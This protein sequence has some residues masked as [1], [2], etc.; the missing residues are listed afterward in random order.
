MTGG[1]ET[2]WIV[3]TLLPL[4]NLLAAAGARSRGSRSNI[5]SLLATSAVTL[6]CTLIAF[7][8]SQTTPARYAENLFYDLRI[9]MAAK[10]ATSPIVIVKIDD[11]ALSQMRDSSECRCLSPIDKAWLADLIVAIGAGRPNAIGIDY[12]LDIWRDPSEYAGFS[13]KISS[14]GSPIIA[15]APPLSRPGIDFSAP[16]AVAYADARA[17]LKDD[18]DDVV[19]S[20][21]PLP[22]GR[23]SFARAIAK[24]LGLNPSVRPMP[25]AFRSPV[26]GAGKENTGALVP[27]VSASIVKDLPSEFFEGKTVLIGRVTRSA[28]TE[29]PD[30]IED[31]HA[32]PLRFLNGHHDGTPGVEVHA[33]ALDQMMRGDTLKSPGWGFMLPFAL[34]AGLAGCIFGRSALR[35][36]AT[37]L[38]IATSLL[39]VMV[40]SVG[41]LW[42][43]GLMIGLTAPALSFIL[44][45][46]ITGRITSTQLRADRALY[47]G[48]LERYL[49]PQVIERIV[50]G[51]EPVEIGASAREI[52]VLASDIADFSVLVGATEP[53]LFSRLINDYFDGVIDI[54]WRYEAMLDKLTGDGLIAIFGAPVEQPDHARRALDCALAIDQFSQ[55]YRAKVASSHQISFG[56]TRIGIHTGQALVGNFGGERRFNYTAYGETVVIAARLEA[57]NKSTGTRILASRETMAHAGDYPGS[58][59]IGDIELKGVAGAV[60]ACTIGT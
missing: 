31:M 23:Q 5:L 10:P 48:T 15:A 35:W 44:A 37:V 36:W 16:S 39:G 43:F 40:A 20:Y 60:G 38:V 45:Y 9:A 19:R 6:A 32:T 57:A 18:Y 54:L 29:S 42:A 3:R 4:R 34:A 13:A 1:S 7:L 59:Q 22:D 24:E 27:S 33:H 25:L 28:G 21:D 11:A 26:A 49:A 8:L 17:L 52:T 47:A 46:F 14:V 41:M 51:G 58:R 56:Q 55:A 30:L 50:E 53:G 12:M 2:S